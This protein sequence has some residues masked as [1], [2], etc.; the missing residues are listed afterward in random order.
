MF[1]FM[2][3][4]IDGCY[5][6]KREGR[7]SVLSANIL[8]AVLMIFYVINKYFCGFMFKTV[9]EG[10]YNVFSDIDMILVATVLVVGCNYLMCT[11]NDGEGK[12]KHI[13][14]SLIYSFAPYL[15][16]MPFLFV[17]THVVTYNEEFFVSFGK[18]VMFVWVAVLAVISIREINNY[19]IKETFKVIF[20]T[21]FTILIVCLL[22][23]IIY[24][25]WSQVFDFLQSLVG[26]VVYRIGS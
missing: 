20:L 18:L 4:P 2:R 16:F 23:F 13:Y 21:A 15:V 26:E 24:V 14:C 12:L 1:T 3:H 17:L 5:G 11:I 6:I 22:A 25:L 19:N 8:L 7:V 9:R 10:S